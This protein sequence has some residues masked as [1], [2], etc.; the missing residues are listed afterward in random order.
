M[1]ESIEYTIMDGKTDTGAGNVIFCQDF[2]HAVIS[3]HTSGNANYTLKFAGSIAEP[4]PNFANAQSVSNQYDFV[5]V[6]DLQDGSAVD[7]DTG[8]TSAGTD[9][10]R[11][12]EVNINGLQ[13]ITSRITA[14][15]SGA[16]T[17]KIRLYND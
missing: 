10:N 4:A 15:S 17:V 2:R 5:E 16:I 3:V 7:G 1:R 6:K 11:L 9:D 8:I 12:F 14:I 13:Y